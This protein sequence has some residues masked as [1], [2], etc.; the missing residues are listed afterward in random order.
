M[1]STPSLPKTSSISFVRV[2]KA[3][4]S[5][6]RALFEVG[7]SAWMDPNFHRRRCFIGMDLENLGNL[8]LESL[9]RGR[10]VENLVGPKSCFCLIFTFW[11]VYN[12]SNWFESS[13]L[14]SLYHLLL[15]PWSVENFMPIGSMGLVYLLSF[16]IKTINY[17][18]RFC[19]PLPWIL[20][21]PM[22]YDHF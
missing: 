6:E 20:Y 21:D 11:G 2:F 8:Y 5:L 22:E 12:H 18:C 4:T 10:V 9:G 15:M 19:I 17:A 1:D 13:G 3:R 7:E 16:T 14:K